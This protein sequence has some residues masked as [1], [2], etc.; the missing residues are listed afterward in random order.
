ML[1]NTYT[2]Y[3]LTK[4]ISTYALVT[5]IIN[6]NLTVLRLTVLTI[7]AIVSNTT[8]AAFRSQFAKLQIADLVNKETGEQ[9]KSLAFSK[10]DGAI[11]FVSFSSKLGPL[12]AKQLKEMKGELQV[13]QLD[14]GNYK[15]CK[16][17]ESTWE[18]VD[19]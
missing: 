1:N 17:G 15:L 2:D 14:S 6:L 19:L 9:F 4:H 13:V 12:T 10:A 8:L 16:Q 18:E 7:M 11:T 5:I 3:I